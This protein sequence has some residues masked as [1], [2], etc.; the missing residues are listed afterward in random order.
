MTPPFPSREEL[1]SRGYSRES[2]DLYDL[3]R[4]AHDEAQQLLRRLPSVFGDPKRPRVT[5]SVAHGFDDEWTLTPERQAELALQDP[6]QHWSEVSDQAMLCSQNYFAFSDAEGWRFYLPA[7][8]SHYLRGFPLNGGYAVVEACRSRTHFDFL[9][10]EQLAFIEDF[11][12]LC[13]TW[14]DD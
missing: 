14:K 11:L 2:L 3:W 1:Q 7:F 10:E 13:D 9:D 8:I 4:T 12:K 6:E 5:L